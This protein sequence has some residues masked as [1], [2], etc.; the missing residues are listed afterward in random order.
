MQ[1]NNKTN[2]SQLFLKHVFTET[3][4]RAIPTAYRPHAVQQW[5]VETPVDVEGMHR[6]IVA[7]LGSA[8]V[9]SVELGIA[10]Y[11]R[12]LR[13]LRACCYMGVFPALPQTVCLHGNYRLHCAGKTV[14]LV[15]MRMFQ[16]ES[17]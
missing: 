4:P 5:I 15:H 3:P 6:D 14:T 1:C 17:V 9:A 2:I 10:S 12:L 11:E 8:E 16:D 7:V 13:D